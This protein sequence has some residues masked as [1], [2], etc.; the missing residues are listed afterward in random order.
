MTADPN[1]RQPR[2]PRQP[3]NP[4]KSESLL[5]LERGV[6]TSTAELREIDANFD[7]DVYDSLTPAEKKARRDR[8]YKLTQK[9]NSYQTE[10]NSRNVIGPL[11]GPGDV[12][13]AFKNRL[14]GFIS[15][16]V[17]YKNKVSKVFKAPDGSI[18]GTIMYYRFPFYYN[19]NIYYAFAHIHGKYMDVSRPGTGAVRMEWVHVGTSTMRDNFEVFEEGN[20]TPICEKFKMEMEPGHIYNTQIKNQIHEGPKDMA[21]ANQNYRLKD[22]NAAVFVDY[23]DYHIYYGYYNGDSTELDWTD[24]QS[25]RTNYHSD[26]IMPPNSG[27]TAV[28]PHTMNHIYY[29]Y[30]S[31]VMMTIFCCIG[32]CCFVFGGIFTALSLLYGFVAT[33]M[34]NKDRVDNANDT[35]LMSG[36]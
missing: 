9:K 14:K 28:N 21:R 6:R 4:L 10:I 32:L 35:D 24:Q 15:N 34:G 26:V 12:C 25:V 3:P 22:Y 18:L 33:K 27:Y 29:G 2:Q 19:R 8:K 11:E 23:S 30:L 20:K 5:K 13:Q 7:Q 16:W 31:I 36:V 1:A 17:W